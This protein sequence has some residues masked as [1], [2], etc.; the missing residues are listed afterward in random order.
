MWQFRVIYTWS[1]KFC[2]QFA[3]LVSEIASTVVKLRHCGAPRQLIN[4]PECLIPASCVCVATIGGIEV[5]LGIRGTPPPSTNCLGQPQKS[6]GHRCK[7]IAFCNSWEYEKLFQFTKKPNW[8]AIGLALMV[9]LIRLIFRISLYKE[10]R[11]KQY[12]E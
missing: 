11:L 6:F 10:S 3:K 12:I 9:V 2:S 7:F 8:C 5:S 1:F 4:F